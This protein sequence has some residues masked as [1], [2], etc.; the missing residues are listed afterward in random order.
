MRMVSPKAAPPLT[1]ILLRAR[2]GRKVRV[3]HLRHD[4][5]D[6]LER[7]FYRLSSESRYRRFFAPVDHVDPGRVR[8]EARRLAT[9]D[10]RRE[11]ALAAVIQEDGAEEVVAVARYTR[12]L[13]NT[14]A[15]EASI[16]VRDDL[17]GQGLGLQLFDLL[18]QVA[19]ARGIEHLVLLTHADNLGMI[20]LVKRLGLPFKGHF[21]SGLY[22]MDVQ[23]TDGLSSYFP[24]S[25]G[26]A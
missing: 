11:V 18:I 20:N 3:R 25:S 16:V 23:L 19:L 4:D 24:F 15:A 7:L 8:E 14:D 1:S 9:I 2:D 6:R 17:Q 13:T 5:A 26:E 10:P 12:L 21:A 22:E